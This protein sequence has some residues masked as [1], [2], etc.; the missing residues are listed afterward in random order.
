VIGVR[1][2]VT[3]MRTEGEG[4][5]VYDCIGGLLLGRGQANAS[6]FK[7]K[8]VRREASKGKRKEKDPKV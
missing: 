6:G 5:V 8:Y 2:K 7:Y 1:S 3:G 4:K